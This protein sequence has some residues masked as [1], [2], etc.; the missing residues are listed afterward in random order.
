MRTDYNITQ[1]NI[2]DLFGVKQP[3]ISDIKRGVKSITLKMGVVLSK[4]NPEKDPI[5][6]TSATY[7]DFESACAEIILKQPNEAAA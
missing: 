4:H 1:Q 2:A 5:Q 3:Y 7:S 6:W